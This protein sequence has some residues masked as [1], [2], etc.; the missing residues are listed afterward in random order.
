MNVTSMF[1][2]A[3]KQ[4]LQHQV[5]TCKMDA[6]NDSEAVVDSQ[7]KVYGVEN[8]RV[9]DASIMPTNRRPSACKA[10]VITATLWNRY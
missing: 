6:F 7:L 3:W 8:L 9:V 4:S 10:D 2:K 1:S 5:G